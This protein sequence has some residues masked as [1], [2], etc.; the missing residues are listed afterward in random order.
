M[1][2]STQKVYEK[3]ESE[4]LPIMKKDRNSPY[5]IGFQEYLDALMCGGYG[6]A[7][8]LCYAD[9]KGNNYDSPI[10]FQFSRTEEKHL[11]DKN[12]LPA[13]KHN[14]SPWKIRF[15][16]ENGYLNEPEMVSQK[17]FETLLRQTIHNLVVIMCVVD[18]VSCDFTLTKMKFQ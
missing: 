9:I 11:K 8:M 10:Y 17:K 2:E 14:Q 6:E 16:D 4:N 7:E 1:N 15:R 12:D 13:K 5:E 18:G 3:G